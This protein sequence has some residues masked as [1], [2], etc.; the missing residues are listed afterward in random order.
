MQTGTSDTRSL[1]TEP[2]RCQA[3]RGHV[4]P[5]LNTLIF[6]SSASQEHGTSLPMQNAAAES[7][8]SMNS[9]YSSFTH[10]PIEES[11]SRYHPQSYTSLSPLMLV[12][13]LCSAT[14]TN[15]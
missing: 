9:P 5:L 13:S 6:S 8:C 7:D 3:S 4:P 10:P 14:D 1:F 15:S 2:Y 12:G 11:Q